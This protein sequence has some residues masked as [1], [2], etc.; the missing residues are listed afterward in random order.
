MD[1][2][3][4]VAR[5]RPGDASYILLA[6]VMAGIA[7]YVC[8]W[9]VYRTQT[10]GAYATFAL[11]WS[12]LH[13]FMGGLSGV[14]QE[15]SRT[16]SRPHVDRASSGLQL[17][18]YAV[19]VCIATALTVGILSLTVG[20]VA[21][22]ESWATLLWPLGV[23][24]VTFAL[25]AIVYGLLS[26]SARWRLV[27]L[28]VALDGLLRLI[29][30]LTIAGANR[31]PVALAWAVALP[32]PVL[33]GVALVGL[34]PHALNSTPVDARLGTL[35]ANTSMTVLAAASTGFLVSGFPLILASAEDRFTEAEFAEI[36]FLMTVMR[37]PLVVSMMA[38][39]SYMTVAFVAAD[40]ASRRLL[41]FLAPTIAA[42][43]LL[44]AAGL[45]AGDQLIQL[46]SG[47]PSVLGN[48][49][50]ALT[51]LSAGLVACMFVLAAALLARR[52]HRSLLLAWV[53]AATT[54]TG[55]VAAELPLSGVDTALTAALAG[56]IVG[57]IAQIGAL[58]AS[59]R[60][61]GTAT[62]PDR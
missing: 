16:T 27:A 33:A 50:L 3:L 11:F 14:Q 49:F 53:L 58:T 37:A 51:L 46:I 6:T 42:T 8:I 57:L 1:R 22:G 25:L 56:P 39:Q 5:S 7:G 60:E 28:I 48:A 17:K 43:A 10:P 18:T 54:T 9:F 52:R 31:D 30:V 13:L 23:G 12:A 15:V 26:G 61:R 35:I 41:H 62:S 2:H 47:R 38:L 21:L 36:V 44:T 55:I 59:R 4:T 19:V 32:I 34:G 45:L 40:L 20:P 29:L 24:A